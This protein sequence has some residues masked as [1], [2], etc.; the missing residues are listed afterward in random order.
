MGKYEVRTEDDFFFEFRPPRLARISNAKLTV[1]TSRFRRGRWAWLS[2]AS[3]CGVAA[4][5]ANCTLCIVNCKSKIVIR[6]SFCHFPE[7]S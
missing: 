5:P 3:P 6:T 2:F 4:K 7:F 1:C